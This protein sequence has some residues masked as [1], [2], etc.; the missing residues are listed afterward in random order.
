MI[1]KHPCDAKTKH[2]TSLL[3]YHVTKYDMSETIF[4][5]QVLIAKLGRKL[6]GKDIQAM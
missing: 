1:W 5:P 4:T 3:K 6:Q 2:S